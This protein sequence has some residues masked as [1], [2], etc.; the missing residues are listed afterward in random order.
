[1][2]KVTVEI[3]PFGSEEGRR[4]LAVMNIGNDMTGTRERGN[5]KCILN[6]DSGEIQQCHVGGIKRGRKYLPQ[7]I[8]AAFQRCYDRSNEDEEHKTEA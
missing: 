2:L 8:A 3:W 5:Y 1:M 6:P 4:T 7:L